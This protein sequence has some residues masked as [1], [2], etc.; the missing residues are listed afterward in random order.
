MAKLLYIVI[1]GWLLF[2][3]MRY[4]ARRLRIRNKRLD[5]LLRQRNEAAAKGRNEIEGLEKYA[6]FG[7]ADSAAFREEAGRGHP[8]QFPP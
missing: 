8:E 3:L 4:S 5:N 7:S 2:L 1:A 6:G